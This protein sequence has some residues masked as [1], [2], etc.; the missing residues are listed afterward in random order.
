MLT[1]INII[2][3]SISIL[4]RMHKTSFVQEDKTKPLL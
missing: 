2:D 1:K 3:E 4:Q